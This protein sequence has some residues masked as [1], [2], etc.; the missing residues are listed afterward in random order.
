VDYALLRSWLGLPSG[1]WP[2][3]HYA[4]LGLEVGQCDPAEVEAIV[5]VRMDRLRMHQLLH[6]ELVTEGMNRLAQALICLTD[7]VARAAHDAELRSPEAE[8]KPLAD[9][10]GMLPSTA[11]PPL[12]S[13]PE[14]PT[15]AAEPLALPVGDWQP[16]TRRELFA[17]LA[18]MRRLLVAWRRLKPA[19]ADPDEPLARPAA[20]L[21]LLEAVAD[22][23]P[24]LDHLQSL[25]ASTGG[26]GT[27][28]ME[29]I[30][31]RFALPTFR[32]LSTEQRGALSLDWRRA[33]QSF[34]HELNRLRELVRTGRPPRRGGHRTGKFFRWATRTPE[35]LLL[36]LAIVT[37]LVVTLRVRCEP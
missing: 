9:T 26:T 28:V 11:N 12:P 32:T 37:V 21:A 1:E 29:M 34:T 16:R 35:V 24:L 3:N 4:L 33:E 7:P 15:P 14:E 17:L 18:V 10:Y 20:V 22:L 30:R 31:Q 27:L 23:R 6:P 19:L 2:P 5:L 8:P 25:V 13:P 36:V